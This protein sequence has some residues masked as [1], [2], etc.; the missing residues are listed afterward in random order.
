[1]GAVC[2]QQGLGEKQRYVLIIFIKNF[3]SLTKACSPVRKSH[4]QA[5]EAQIA[6]LQQFIRSLRDADSQRREE[7]LANFD[8]SVSSELDLSPESRQSTNG[9]IENSVSALTRSGQLRKLRGGSASHFYGVTSLFQF[10]SLE[11]LGKLSPR[12][13]FN[14]PNGAST[15]SSAVSRPDTH[16]KAH[17]LQLD[18][19]RFDYTPRGDIVKK[20]L[21]AFFKNQYQY[22]ICVY[23]EFFLRDY[24][25]GGGKY[26]SD[27]FLWAICATSALATDNSRCRL[28]LSETFSQKAQSLLYSSLDSPDLTTLQALVL[29]GQLEISYGRS[30]K[31]WLLSGMASRLAHEMGLHIDPSNW[32]RSGEPPVDQ[33]I[34]RRVYWATF[35]VDTQLSL[36]FGRP[37][38]LFPYKSDV[39]DAIRLPYPRE[40][41]LLLDK[42]IAKGVTT[43]TFEDGIAFVGSF[44][45]QVDLYKILH[46]MVTQVLEN[47]CANA[48]SKLL[49]HNT[50][51][52]HLSL[53]RWSA[54]LPAKFHWNQWV[55]GHIPACVLHLQ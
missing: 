51:Q 45:Y 29:L 18:A 41:E 13:S 2:T 10:N 9:G 4:V 33:E 11:E 36:H 46:S 27:L 53:T 6:S 26:Y 5:L 15:L 47:R 40:W 49:T 19:S 38:A 32:N 25:V 3:R 20:L 16:L 43:D 8:L 37:P 52:I 7:L 1:M 28:E 12:T 50:R 42:Y 22:N 30:S 21:A 31:G 39:N 54:N 24:D 48:N 55:A 23:R 35:I 34:L 44:I 14:V 17:E